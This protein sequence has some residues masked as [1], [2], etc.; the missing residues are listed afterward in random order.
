MKIYQ[1]V[2]F[3]ISSFCLFHHYT[4]MGQVEMLSIGNAWSNWQRWWWWLLTHVD[5]TLLDYVWSVQD[6]I[7]IYNSE[8]SPLVHL[9]KG[10]SARSNIDTMMS[11]V[12]YPIIDLNYHRTNMVTIRRRESV[13]W[14]ISSARDRHVH[15]FVLVHYYNEA[16]GNGH[17]L[18]TN[19]LSKRW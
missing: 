7:F 15:R 17:E 6:G 2:T 8:N 9:L 13:Y 18:I 19:C 5:G 3:I 4:C 14:L 11:C 10:T 1:L 16:C 12:M